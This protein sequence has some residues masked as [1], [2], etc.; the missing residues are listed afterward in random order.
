MTQSEENKIM[1]GLDSAE[2]QFCE[3][4]KYLKEVLKSSLYMVLE[5]TYHDH[6]T[7]TKAQRIL[8]RWVA[9][10]KLSMNRVRFGR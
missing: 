10:E 9:I 4:S 8:N 5:S 6:W 1:E 7:L 3:S 2:Q